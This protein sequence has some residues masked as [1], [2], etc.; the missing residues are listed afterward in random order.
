MTS[1]VLGI[2]SISST[3]TATRQPSSARSMPVTDSGVLPVIDWTTSRAAPAMRAPDVLCGGASAEA[4]A[5][6]LLLRVVFLAGGAFSV[7]A[8]LAD[9]VVADDFLA[10]VF[11]A[12]VFLAGLFEPAF[13]VAVVSAMTLLSHLLA[14]HQSLHQRVLTGCRLVVGQFARDT[15]DV[16]LLQLG[17]DRH[18]VVELVLRLALHLL[19]HRHDTAQWRQRSGEQTSQ[20]AHQPPPTKS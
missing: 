2:R 13:F 12:D 4:L 11:L 20:Q 14:D 17:P 8:F 10:G 7:V 9:E 3:S 6:A 16:D 19:G 5:C 15:Q 18:R 1:V